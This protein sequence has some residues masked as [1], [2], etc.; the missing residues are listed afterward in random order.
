MDREA[1]ESSFERLAAIQST[2]ADVERRR[3]FGRDGLTVRGKFFA[4]LDADRLLLKLPW[5]RRDALLAQ[6][7]AASAVSVSPGPAPSR[8]VPRPSE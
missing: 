3:M 5:A 1:A 4:F 8:T 6:G 7:H 2:R